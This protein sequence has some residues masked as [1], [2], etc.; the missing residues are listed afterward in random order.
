MSQLAALRK[1]L[2]E[3]P[4]HLWT[5]QV[6]AIL[7]IEIGRNLRRRRAI[8]LYLLAALPLLIV[9]MVPLVRNFSLEEETQILAFLFQNVYLRLIVFG[10]CVGL[11]T[12]ILRG[13]MVQKTLHYYFLV[14][15]RRQVLLVGKFLA[16]LVTAAIV[17]GVSVFLSFAFMYGHFGSQGVS[18]VLHGP[19]LAQL[20]T[21]LGVTLLACLGYGAIFATLSLFIRNP[22]I[23]A[24]VVLLWETFHPVFPAFLQKLSVMFYLRQLCPVLAPQEDISALFTVIAEPVSAWIAVPGLLCLSVVLLA[25]AC[26]RIQRTEIS[27]LA[28]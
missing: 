24:L 27:Y 11:F 25:I 12:W 15:V 18:Y 3:A 2:R 19:G 16:A 9:P 6:A 23:P 22:I 5:A 14:P 21:Y 26:W 1:V 8:W 17:F 20:A 13:E 7:R 4:W 10:G 28:E